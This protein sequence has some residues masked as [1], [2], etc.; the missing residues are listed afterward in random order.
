MNL[1]T[2]R[3]KWKTLAWKCLFDKG[4]RVYFEEVIAY[5]LRN[6][7]EKRGQY[8]SG[9]LLFKGAGY[10]EEITEKKP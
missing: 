7:E 9:I 10:E 6:A 3:I 2:H 4:F 1:T 5:A 8:A